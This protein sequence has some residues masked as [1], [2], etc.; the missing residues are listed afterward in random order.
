MTF[1]TSMH[2]TI[3]PGSYRPHALPTPERPISNR[4]THMTHMTLRQRVRN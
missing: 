4:N 2:F 1:A 3:L